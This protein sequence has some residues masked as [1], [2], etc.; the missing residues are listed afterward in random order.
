VEI[1]KVTFRSELENLGD[2][3]NAVMSKMIVLP[4]IVWP[5]PFPDKAW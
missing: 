5:T 3:K 2:A 1:G 4:K